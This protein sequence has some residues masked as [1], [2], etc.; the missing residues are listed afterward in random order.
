LAP[1]CGRRARSALPSPAFSSTK[2]H[3]ATLVPPL[4]RLCPQWAAPR[5]ASVPIASGPV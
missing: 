1:L 5:A 2:S 3:H 4:L